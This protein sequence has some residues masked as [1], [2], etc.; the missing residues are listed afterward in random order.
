[1]F[2][3]IVILIALSA[4]I[5][6][7]MSYAQIGVTWLL[8][9]HDWVSQ[10]LTDVFSAGQAGNVARGLIALLSIPVIVGLI[11]A[12]VYWFLRRHWF[13]YFMPIVWVVWLI[14][15]GALLM[16]YKTTAM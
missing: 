6:F 12:I 1:M 15:A 14:Q 16:V 3:Q 10:L 11:P 2:K 8:T 13:P 7:A 4:A 9:A 5:V